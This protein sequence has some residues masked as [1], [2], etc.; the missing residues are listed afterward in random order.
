MRNQII[1]VDGHNYKHAG[2]SDAALLLT[3]SKPATMREFEE[4]VAKPGLMTFALRVPYQDIISL[5]QNSAEKAVKIKYR[6]DKGKEKNL[7]IGLD[8][9]AGA[10]E[11]AQ[12]LGLACELTAKSSSESQLQPL[13]INLLLVLFAGGFTAFVALSPAEEIQTNGRRRGSAAILR[14]LRETL[15]STGV[16]IVGGLITAYLIYQLYQRYQSPATVTEWR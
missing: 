14:M 9:S 6:N 12:T 1:P 11:F 13:L 5:R 4:T 16:W 10:G 2:L 7:S 8:D 3:S 15:G